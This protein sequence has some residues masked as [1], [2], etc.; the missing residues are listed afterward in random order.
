MFDVDPTEGLTLV[1]IAEGVTEDEV[2][3]ATGCSYK[4]FSHYFLF[5]IIPT[6]QVA[7]KLNPMSQV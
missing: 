3:K 1:E 2:A 6:L 4:V 5:Y 7:E